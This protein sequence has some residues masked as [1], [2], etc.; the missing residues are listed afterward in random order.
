LIEAIFVVMGTSDTSVCQC[1]LA[2]DKWE[3][4]QVAP[5][6][7]ML[8]HVID[9]NRMS[10]SV[11]NNFIQSVR[12][13]I[14]STWHTH[15]QLFTVKE[16]QELT[17]KLGH[18]AEGANWVF[19]LRTHLYASIAYALSENKRFLEDHSPEFQTLIKSLQSGYFFCNFKDQI[20]HI[21]F[22]IK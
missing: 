18:L 5:I 1:S 2:M 3:K 13:L 16:A 11:P 14:D 4:L 8:G 6:Q 22:A 19:H 10:V 17:G 9:T 21:S 7:T 15:C 20:H 12:L